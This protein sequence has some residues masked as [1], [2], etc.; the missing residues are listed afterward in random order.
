MRMS[1]RGLIAGMAALG[2]PPVAATA[3]SH[4]PNRPG[5]MGRI[6]ILALG[7][8]D[9]ARPL[10]EGAKAFFRT[11][12]GR[13]IRYRMKQAIIDEPDLMLL[14]RAEGV[15]TVLLFGSDADL[16]LASEMVRGAGGS[17]L[18]MAH[19]RGPA[20]ASMGAERLRLAGLQLARLAAGAAGVQ[21][22][23]DYPAGPPFM[24]ARFSPH[25]PANMA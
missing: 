2:V 21:R 11:Q 5:E 24:I 10:L 23:S 14:T 13:R 15:R 7:H 1:R 19:R 20:P 8:R 17:V 9:F 18:A 4:S 6:E 25:R 16:L 3:R 22:I 12:E